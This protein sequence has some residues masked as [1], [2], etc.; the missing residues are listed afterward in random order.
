MNIKMKTMTFTFLKFKGLEQFF[1]QKNI[2]RNAVI[3]DI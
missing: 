2:L 1:L 3:F